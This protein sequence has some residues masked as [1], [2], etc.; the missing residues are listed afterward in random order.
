MSTKNQPAFGEVNKS[1]VGNIFSKNDRFILNTLFYPFS[2][3]F[4]Y[5][6]ENLKK[7]KSNLCKIRPMLNE[8][9]GFEE[10]IISSTKSDM[11]EF[12]KSEMF[13][14]MRAKMIERWEVLKKFNTYPNM[15]KPLR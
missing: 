11:K 4:G 13:I 10:A 14:Y 2:V 6:E 5:E 8:T 15:L 1:K 12:K 3:A 9:F 7:F